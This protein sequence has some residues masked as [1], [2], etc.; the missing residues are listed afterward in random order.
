MADENDTATEARVIA[1]VD[2]RLTEMGIAFPK[3]FRDS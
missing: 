2:A 1:E 3:K